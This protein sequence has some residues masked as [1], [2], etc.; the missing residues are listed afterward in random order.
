MWSGNP[1]AY[2]DAYG[3]IITDLK[4]AKTSVDWEQL[5]VL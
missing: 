1:S 4:I 2:V 5:H 3:E